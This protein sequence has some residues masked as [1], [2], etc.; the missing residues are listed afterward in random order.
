MTKMNWD[1]THEEGAVKDRG[2]TVSHDRPRDAF[3]KAEPKYGVG[4]V[5]SLRS[6]EVAH[7]QEAVKGHRLCP[8]CGKVFTKAI[9]LQ[10]HMDAKHPEE[11]PGP[12][13]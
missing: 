1:R 7:T 3:S 8:V 9:G 11:G 5:W 6:R 4:L 12:S 10:N 13:R 2:A